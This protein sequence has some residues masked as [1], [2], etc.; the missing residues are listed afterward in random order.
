MSSKLVIE[1]HCLRKRK[2]RLA[3]PKSPE[4]GL[5]D[6]ILRKN[7]RRVAVRFERRRLDAGTSVVA[8]RRQ[9]GGVRSRQASM[10]KVT[11][12]AGRNQATPT[13]RIPHICGKLELGGTKRGQLS[14]GIRSREYER[15][16]VDPSALMAALGPGSRSCPSGGWR[17]K[18]TETQKSCPGEGGGRS[19]FQLPGT[20]I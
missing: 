16:A 11:F 18:A 9:G 7:C 3:L 10:P 19:R 5:L 2:K 8:Y 17:A 12:N 6:S 20:G 14:L 15:W 1:R 13:H 4:V